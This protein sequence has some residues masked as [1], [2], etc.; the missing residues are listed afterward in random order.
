M[1]KLPHG[2]I[3]IDKGNPS[4][5]IDFV[6]ECGMALISN[7]DQLDRDVWTGNNG[8]VHLG[9]EKE[10]IT[11]TSISDL[12][13]ILNNLLLET[14]AILSE[15]TPIDPRD[16][17][18]YSNFEGLKIEALI[19]QLVFDVLADKY[20]HESELMTRYNYSKNM[21]ENL[22]TDP[23]QKMAYTRAT[24]AKLTRG[25]ETHHDR[26]AYSNLSKQIMLFGIDPQ[27]YAELYNSHMRENPNPEK[28]KFF[29][30]MLYYNFCLD[31]THKQ[32][33]RQ[34][35]RGNRNYSYEE[36][37]NDLK[38]YSD[39]VTKQLPVEYESHEKYFRMSMD[40]YFMESY[41]RVDFI[42]K[43]IAVLDPDEIASID[44]KH[45]F[46]S[47]FIPPV[48]VPYVQ[49]GELNFKFQPKYYKP[50]FMI[51]D[52]LLRELP[53]KRAQ[54]KEDFPQ[55]EQMVTNSC[56]RNIFKPRSLLSAAISTV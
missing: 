26:L 45:F 8:E 38:S 40:Y 25:M 18:T 42:F 50:L 35:A 9:G 48:L 53:I 14:E 32:Y 51:E 3:S 44:R 4:R 31:L 20:L 34:F 10:R 1:S 2:I 6:V 13:D 12:R 24:Y 47:R 46:V 22:Y 17:Y 54:L 52:M 28:P 41:K 21:A 19:E 30:D 43:L 11:L 15:H 7:Y 5:T 55:E 36:T 56:Y 29:W 27:K 37:F 33:Q 49:D 23:T 16:P 39:F